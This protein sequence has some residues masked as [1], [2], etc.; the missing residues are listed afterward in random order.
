MDILCLQGVYFTDVQRLIYQSLKQTYPYIY[1]TVDF[2]AEFNAQRPACTPDDASRF[3]SCAQ[4]NGCTDLA[5]VV[6]R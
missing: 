1:S 6:T 2:A 5:C 4:Q 3:G